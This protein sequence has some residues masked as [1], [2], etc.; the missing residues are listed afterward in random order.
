MLSV[1][2][3]KHIE[4]TSK[5]LGVDISG[6]QV[7][8]SVNGHG[9]PLGSIIVHNYRPGFNAEIAIATT[10]AG[11]TRPL[12]RYVAAYLFGQL[13]LPRISIIVR[14]TDESQLAIVLRL[15]FEA[16]GVLKD[17]YGPGIDGIHFRLTLAMLAA[18]KFRK[19]LEDSNGRSQDEAT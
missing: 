1:V 12:I 4:W 2:V 15:G 13:E 19:V 11:L 9:Q 8:T 14:A 3:N 17:W 18:T 10:K 6:W 5:L 7:F 16:E